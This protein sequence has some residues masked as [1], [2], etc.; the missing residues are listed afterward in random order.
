MKNQD[1]IIDS[2]P[3]ER[4]LGIQWNLEHD[5]LGFCVHLKGTPATRRRILSTVSSIYNPLGFVAP[6][7]LPGRKTIQRLCQ[8][9]VK[10]DDPVSCDIRKDC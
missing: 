8:G 1:L 4:T 9:E 2:L 7:I 3:K 5:Y 10:W 6:F